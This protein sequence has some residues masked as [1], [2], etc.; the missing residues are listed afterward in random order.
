MTDFVR[1]PSGSPR[2]GWARV[3]TSPLYRGASDLLTSTERRRFWFLA[4]LPVAW[5]L[6]SNVGPIAQMVRISFLSG[7]PPT[8]GREPE[9]T[10]AHWL[11]FFQEPVYNTPL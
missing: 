7:Y 3:A 8:A 5:I 10:V 1:S 4:S 11:L 2:G 6:F 9:W